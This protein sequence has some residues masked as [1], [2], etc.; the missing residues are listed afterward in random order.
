MRRTR[1]GALPAPLALAA[2]VHS[3]AGQPGGGHPR[4]GGDMPRHDVCTVETVRVSRV[5]MRAGPA[6][7]AVRVTRRDQVVT[8]PDSAGLPA[9]RGTGRPTS[10]RR[11]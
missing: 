5:T 1:T 4:R 9:W 11:P 7:I 6:I 8:L 10:P 3:V 2:A